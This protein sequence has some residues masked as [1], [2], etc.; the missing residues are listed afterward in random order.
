MMD[1]I[2]LSKASTNI[3]VT[4]K[5]ELDYMLQCVYFKGEIKSKRLSDEVIRPVSLY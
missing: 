5:S 2:R 3:P 1:D 4:V